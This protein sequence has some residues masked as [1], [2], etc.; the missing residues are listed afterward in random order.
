MQ[1]PAA[2]LSA[3]WS[4]PIL[5]GLLRLDSTYML[6]L[7]QRLAAV[8]SLAALTAACAT[9]PDDNTVTV[10][11]NAGVYKIGKPYQNALA[12]HS[13]PTAWVLQRSSGSQCSLHGS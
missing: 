5:R 13:G 11:P 2:A 4:S 12:M 8:I 10:P 7:A 3:F 1:R 6:N 9:S